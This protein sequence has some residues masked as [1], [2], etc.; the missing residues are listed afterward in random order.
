MSAHLFQIVD[1]SDTIAA[2][3][4]AALVDTMGFVLSV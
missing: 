2:N 4:G 3:T 1:N